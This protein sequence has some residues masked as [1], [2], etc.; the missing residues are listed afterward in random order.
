M[1]GKK[2]FIAASLS[3][4]ALGLVLFFF[5]NLTTSLICT[6]AGLLLLAYGVSAGI[7]FFASSNGGYRPQFDAVLG[8]FAA[9]LGVLFLLKPQMILSILPV[10]FGLYILVDGL[11]NLKRGQIGR[12]SCRERV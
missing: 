1:N 12:A 8:V 2:S 3:Y 4:V 6:V 11:T 9:V 10:I 5:P 7:S